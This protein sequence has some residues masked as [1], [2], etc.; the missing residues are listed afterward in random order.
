M[1]YDSAGFAGRSTAVVASSSNSG[2]EVLGGF[3]IVELPTKDIRISKPDLKK[4]SWRSMDA[5]CNAIQ[6]PTPSM[7]D[8]ASSSCHLDMIILE[9][10]RILAF[11]E[12]LLLIRRRECF[13][14]LTRRRLKRARSIRVRRVPFHATYASQR[15]ARSLRCIKHLPGSNSSAAAS[16]WMTLSLASA[17][18]RPLIQV[19]ASSAYR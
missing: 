4:S 1:K 12:T 8:D 3:S 6:N 15:A 7:I 14:V 10:N 2:L 16:F 18:Q 19:G 5:D 17:A 9:L 11:K 13:D